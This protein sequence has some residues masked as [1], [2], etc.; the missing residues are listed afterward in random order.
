MAAIVVCDLCG[1][2][3]PDD[4]YVGH[5]WPCLRLQS[6]QKGHDGGTLKEESELDCC[7]KCRDRA[8]TELIALVEGLKDD[9]DSR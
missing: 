3:I 2:A 1:K 9:L 5:E 4:D 8:L 7:I 6:G